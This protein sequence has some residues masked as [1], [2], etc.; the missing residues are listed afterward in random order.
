MKTIF[1]PEIRKGLIK[2]VEKLTDNHS[3]KWGKMNAFKMV[4]HMNIWNEWV[5]NEGNLSHKQSLLGKLIGKWMLKKDTKDDA[6]MSKSMP[7]GKGFTIAE[8]EGDFIKE[9]E[10]WINFITRYKDFPESYFDHDFYGKMT[11]EQ[12]GIFSY[13]HH[14]HHLRQ[15]NV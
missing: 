3:A 2:R 7:S 6:L 15:F 12:I 10:K 13:K 11:R 9:K 5:F 14:D 1:D 4:S 8:I